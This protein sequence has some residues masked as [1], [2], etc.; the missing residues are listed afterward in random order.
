[1]QAAGASHFLQLALEAGNAVA[2][3]ATVRLDLR[4]A[5]AAE[6]AEATALTS[7]VGPGPDEAAA[8][9]F[10]VRQLDL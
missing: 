4:L 5:G 7:E 6:E 9:I 2:D 8:L 1:V 3:Q 10:E